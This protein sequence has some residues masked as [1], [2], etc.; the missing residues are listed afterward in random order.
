MFAI[1]TDELGNT[2]AQN[3][4]FIVHIS[5]IKEDSTIVVTSS[6]DIAAK[7]I[8]NI[9][10]S[11][12][13][14][15]DPTNK[16]YSA[17]LSD[18]TPESGLTISRVEELAENAQ[19]NLKS[20]LTI[21]DLVRRYINTDDIFGITYEAI[22]SNVNTEI[23]L[24]YNDK[25]V[26]KHKIKTNTLKNAKSTIAAFNEEINL[27][28]YIRTAIPQTFSEGTFITYLR[29]VGE[30]YV[31]D[32][33]PLGVAEISDYT[34]NG[35]PVV[36]VDMNELK[37]RLRKT[38][39]KKRD[40]SPLF[41]NNVQEEINNNY[42]KEVID[43][44]N[45]NEAYAVL[46]HTRTGVVRINNLNRKYGLTPFFRAL[47][48]AIMLDNFG[49]S[50]LTNSKAKAKKII[51]QK[52]RAELLDSDSKTRAWEEQSYAHQNLVKAFSQPTVLYTGTPAVE[53]LEYI[54]PSVDM[55]PIDTINSYRTREMTTL[56]INFLNMQD[57][58]TVTT[59]NISVTQLLLTINKISER[60]EAI[61]KDWYK[62]VL[63]EKKIGAEY[64]PTIKIIDSEQLAMDMK[65]SLVE[66]LFSKL[67]CSYQTAFE[68]VGIDVEDEIQRRQAENKEQY[69]D[70]FVPHPSQYTTSNSPSDDSS[71]GRPK[72]EVVND[73]DKQKYDEQ[74]NEK[75][76]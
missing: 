70:I 22:E 49:N 45:A 9:L 50:D 35:K 13:N 66:L 57:G 27:Q 31:V 59:A 60:L 40:N 24:M 71:P 65:K 72:E 6:E 53:N 15:Y 32:F 38:Y 37:S 41:F 8:D 58:Q 18:K 25:G 62:L 11:A 56:G 23:R 21:N 74:Y 42:P 63:E 12:L 39:R 4:D 33:Y 61:I 2:S 54:E 36:I 47:K 73:E 10:L 55:T 26:E 48:P 51:F 67:N 5:P 29:T 3:E 52:I 44:Y 1:S 75:N 46:D 7:K 69:D 68:M 64:A 28:N 20:I 19:T 14:E 30:N 34:V 17:Y 16:R 76:R 43:A